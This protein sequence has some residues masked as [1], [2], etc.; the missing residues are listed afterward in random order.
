LAVALLLLGFCRLWQV[1]RNK[2][3]I[4]VDLQTLLPAA[5]MQALQDAALGPFLHSLAAAASGADHSGGATLAKT[6]EW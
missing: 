4:I 5:A 1:L 3:R 6:D 2:A